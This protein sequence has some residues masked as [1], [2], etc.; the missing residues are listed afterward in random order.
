MPSI[1][2]RSE[3]STVDFLATKARVNQTSLALILQPLVET[4]NAGGFFLR[5]F[6]KTKCFLPLMAFF[7]QDSKEGNALAGCFGTWNCQRPCRFCW[8]EFEDMNKVDCAATELREMED[9][10]NLIGPLADTIRNR[11][12]GQI[13]RAREEA[14][15]M[16]VQPM[17]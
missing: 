7:A 17:R 15:E 4:F 2:S 12:H 9:V 5:M 13:G 14:K 3:K 6:D 10:A 8:T 16:S 1:E 11:V